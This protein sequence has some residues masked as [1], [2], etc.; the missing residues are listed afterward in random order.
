MDRPLGPVDPEESDELERLRRRAY[1]PGAD[2]AGDAAA[3]ARLT[4]LEAAQRRPRT[5][6]VDTVAWVP[7]QVEERVSD[8]A[9]AGGSDNER[10][11]TQESTA[12]SDAADRAPAARRRRWWAF[13]SIAI[14]DVALLAVLLTWVWPREEEH[15]PSPDFGRSADS[16]SFGRSADFVLTLESVGADADEPKDPHGTLDRLGLNIDQMRRYEDIGYLSV[17]SGESRDGTVCLLVAHPGQGLNEGIGF[18]RCEP[19]GVEIT[20]YLSVPN[21]SYIQFVLKEDHVDVYINRRVA[22]PAAP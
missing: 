7:A 19:E 3:Q 15:V 20:G 13:I 9:P 4:E 6:V 12:G 21:G 8:A 10:N 14:A 18:E 2:I 16:P 22:D 1:G 17:W 11:P 5:P